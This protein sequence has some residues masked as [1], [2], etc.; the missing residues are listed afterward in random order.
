MKRVALVLVAVLG[1][2]SAQAVQAEEQA[3]PTTSM[4]TLVVTATKTEHSLGDVPAS[5]S[6]VTREEIETMPA[7]SV[8]DV[9]K[10]LPGVSVASERGV[11]GTSTSNNVIIRGFGGNSP[12]R[13]LV[14]IDGMPMNAPGSTIFEWTS[15]N[16]ENVERVE[17]VRGPASALYGSSAMGGAINIITRKPSEDGFE[18][19]LDAKYGTFNTWQTS[20]FHSGR[21]GRFGYWI[22]GDMLNTHGFNALTQEK[23]TTRNSD[24]ERIESYNGALSLTYNIDETFDLTFMA[25]IDS[26]ERRG[27]YAFDDEF[28]LYTYD[29]KGFA[30]KARKDFGFM[31]S[32][33]TMRADILESN[34]DMQDSTANAKVITYDAPA[35]QEMYSGDLQNS[36][37]LGDW[38]YVTVGVA[39]SYGTQDR[40]MNYF[41]TDRYRERGGEQ[42]NLAFYVQ[43]E[44]SLLDGDLLIVPGLRY[45][46]WRTDGYDLDTLIQDDRKE[47][48][49]DT[50]QHL[51]PKL[52]LRYTM[53]E[54]VLTWRASY[55]HGFRV[56]S[57]DD[58]FGEFI[59]GTTIYRGNPDLDP[60][61][62]DTFELGLDF[63]PTRTLTFSGAVFKTLAEDFI[64]TIDLPD[65]GEHH[66]KFKENI[67]KVEITGVELNAEYRPNEHWK[68]F[69]DWTGLNPLIDSGEFKGKQVPNTPLNKASFGFVFDNPDWFKLRLAGNWIGKTWTS[70]ANTD[71]TGEVLTFDAR[72][73]RRFDIDELL[74]IEPYL[75]AQNLQ[76]GNEV[77]LSSSSRMP[78]NLFFAGLRV[79]F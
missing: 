59:S 45:D 36:F 78:T 74:W 23:Q 66:I 8:L 30:G 6:V 72:V 43:D 79:G 69:A 31:E 2:L 76:H 55:G 34:Y 68:F 1:L 14:M 61:I 38:N 35:Y 51:S 17:V 60:E 9:I 57:L 26:Y 41:T 12:G 44:I 22:S 47:Y 11:Y 37:A 10:Q 64:A 56:G 33:L 48:D 40:D 39:G 21:V 46:Y 32:T 58:R 52:G 3:K 70:Q 67:D 77:L 19:T 49:T 27:R 63:S 18:T 50:N 15:L 13:V 73:S 62:S 54:D 53:I 4:D 20:A 75:E 5:M 28:R 71:S 65:E 24:P 7:N 42:I 25:D 29:R 16:L